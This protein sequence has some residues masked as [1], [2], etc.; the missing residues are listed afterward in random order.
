MP[1]S[2]CVKT[3]DSVAIP[4]IC[5]IFTGMSRKNR[6]RYWWVWLPVLFYT[7]W[8]FR[9]SMMIAE[10]S[11]VMSYSVSYKLI[12]FLQRLGLYADFPVFHH[13][14]RKLAHFTEFAGLGF[15]VGIAMKLCPLFRSRILNFL[16]FLLII[17][18]TDEM[19]Q[20]FYEG[21]ATQV[22][23]MF[24]DGGGMLA[25]GFCAYVLILIIL[26]LFGG[27]HER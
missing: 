5:A 12:A 11:N 23:D 21:R 17:P 25:G 27:R 4:F 20:H 15:L 9:N 7:G 1:Y 2:H 19:L 16:L 8:I 14:V 24:I 6:F 22:T 13:Y 18:F 3:C 26:D 10:A